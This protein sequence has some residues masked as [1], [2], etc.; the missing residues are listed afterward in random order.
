LFSTSDREALAARLRVRFA[1]ADF[2]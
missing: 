2:Q 1:G